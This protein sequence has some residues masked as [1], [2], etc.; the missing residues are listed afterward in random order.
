MDLKDAYFHFSIHQDHWKYLWFAI[1]G[2]CY[3]YKVLPFGLTT[4]P[5]VFTK[6]LAPVM[7]FLHL[8]GVKVFP[9]LDDILFSVAS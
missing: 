5:Q 1:Q 9:Y 3:Q 2:T 8:Q 6:M 7:A 4:S